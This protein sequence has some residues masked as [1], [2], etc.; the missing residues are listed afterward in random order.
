MY[1]AQDRNTSEIVALKRIRLDNAEE[2]VPF[3][4]LREISLLKEVRATLA[5]RIGARAVWGLTSAATALHSS[6]SLSSSEELGGEE[7]GGVTGSV[8]MRIYVGPCR[9]AIG[10]PGYHRR[11][12]RRAGVCDM[13]AKLGCSAGSDPSLST[14]LCESR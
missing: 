6:V 13:R 1:K 4:A 12:C 3:T 14:A 11:D 9:T 8:G 5:D 2:G 10:S 7:S